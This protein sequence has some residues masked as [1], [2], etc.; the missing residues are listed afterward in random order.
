M[1]LTLRTLIAWMDDTLPPKDVARI[2]RQLQ[3]SKFAQDLGQ[4]IHRVIRQRRLSIPGMGPN[5]PIDANI[6]SAYLDN[7]LPPEQ[8]AAVESLC[9]NSDVHLAEV[10][11][12]HQ[13]L[14]LLEQP[15]EV[16]PSQYSAMY[17]LVKGNESRLPSDHEV[18]RQIAR[19]AGPPSGRNALLL[20]SNKHSL[21]PEILAALES[22]RS[23]G[24]FLI[25][26]NAILIAAM[27]AFP[28][29]LNSISG[30]QTGQNRANLNATLIEKTPVADLAPPTNKKDEKTVLKNDMETKAD[31]AEL[32]SEVEAIKPSEPE[33][34]SNKVE[35]KPAS[36]NEAPKVANL[37][38]Q[39]NILLPISDVLKEFNRSLLFFAESSTV[40]NVNENNWSLV[41][42]LI[43]AGSGSV[44][45]A[46]PEP[47]K[48]ILASGE[49][50]ILP[51]TLLK[52]HKSAG[53][54]IAT[55]LLQNGGLQLR[56]N[57]AKK[58]TLA[59][60]S[61]TFL[62]CHMTA[63]SSCVIKTSSLIDQSKPNLDINRRFEIICEKGSCSIEIR[64]T[65]SSKNSEI[66][67]ITGNSIEIQHDRDAGWKSAAV[68]NVNNSGWPTETTS[69]QLASAQLSRYLRNN[70][71]IATKL[72]EATNDKQKLV[73]SQ[74]VKIAIWSGRRDLI[75]QPANEQGSSEIR[76]SVIDAIRDGYESGDTEASLLLED[77]MRTIQNPETSGPR[78][79]QF[80]AQPGEKS[81]SLNPAE[82]V[83]SLQDM[84]VLVRELA[85]DHLKSISGRD[86]L[87]YNPDMPDENGLKAWAKWLEMQKMAN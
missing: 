39:D 81:K 24:R 51:G 33:K 76:R 14:V 9:L 28:L 62:V 83:A 3:N 56:A 49:V 29:W 32:K 4:R 34:I 20:S 35:T 18:Y 19:S 82:M 23:S 22:R 25:A 66:Q 84:N 47:L 43:E 2:G 44:R 64:N 53:N 42:T 31:P 72:M 45:F 40:P 61:N 68:N 17:R 85:L 37:P 7:S 69:L 65:N 21:S 52:W 11:A 60:S 10:A 16:S 87:E 12:C 13:I 55:P 58:I 67:L 75:L 86:N 48:I 36:E 74:A 5:T 70:R 63:E 50:G 59:L 30:P 15:V 80:I 6:V 54:E 57:S 27:A 8:L 26:M 77:L 73:R 1:R 38:A 79:T 46:D 71:P 41:S 78:L